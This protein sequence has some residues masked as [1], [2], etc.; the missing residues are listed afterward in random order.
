MYVYL[1]L[2]LILIAFLCICCCFCT[3]V[4]YTRNLYHKFVCCHFISYFL[5]LQLFHRKTNSVFPYCTRNRRNVIANTEPRRKIEAI[6][7]PRIYL[8]N[9]LVYW[10]RDNWFRA[11]TVGGVDANPRQWKSSYTRRQLERTHSDG[12]YV[13]TVDW[14]SSIVVNVQAWNAWMNGFRR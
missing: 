7:T 10:G 8:C 14:S 12:I 4:F 6:S 1:F 9:W 11:N 3:N 13:R 5:I 2:L